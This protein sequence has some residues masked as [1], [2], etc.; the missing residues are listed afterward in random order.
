MPAPV[1]HE[2]KR[3]PLVTRTLAAE[4]ERDDALRSITDAEA[5]G[6]QIQ[7]LVGWRTPVSVNI[8]MLNYTGSARPYGLVVKLNL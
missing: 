7:T 2:V 1:L 3:K 4:Q 5:T 8:D 6:K